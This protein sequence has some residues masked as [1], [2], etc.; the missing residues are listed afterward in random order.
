VFRANAGGSH[1]PNSSYPRS[2]LREMTN[3][4]SSNAAWNPSSGTHTMT[5]NLSMSTGTLVA[6]KHVV[7]AQVHDANDDVCVFRLEDTS[8]Y[9]T[10]GDDPHGTLITSSYV[11]GTMFEAKF[12]GSGGSI[13]CYYNGSL[14]ATRPCGGGAYFKAGCYTQSNTSKGDAANAY[15]EVRIR[16]VV[17]SHG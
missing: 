6:K 14:V 17:V 1:T 5:V 7:G 12:V 15:G 13:K 16:S 3:G 11:G 2:E 9:V 8:L 10:N 4:G